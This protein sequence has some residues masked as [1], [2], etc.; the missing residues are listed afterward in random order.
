MI[1]RNANMTSFC[2]SVQTARCGCTHRGGEILG[3]PA[4]G[5]LREGSLAATALLSQAERYDL[6]IS[7][8]DYRG[9]FEG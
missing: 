8:E 7:R 6:L 5:Q 2:G 4:Y 3:L 9:S 1:I